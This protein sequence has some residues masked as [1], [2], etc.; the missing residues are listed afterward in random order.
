MQK[1]LLWSRRLAMPPPGKAIFT[2]P[3]V[4]RRKRNCRCCLS[5]RTT[6]TASVVPPAKSIP[7]P[8]MWF[9]RMIG[10]NSTAP[11]LG[12][13]MGQAPKAFAHIRAGEGP[14]FFWVMMERLSSHTSS[15]DQKLYRSAEELKRCEGCD[16]LRKW[17]EQLIAEGVMSE[18][19]YANL[20]N[21]IKERI[22][23]EFSDAEKEQDPSA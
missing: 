12:K 4:S 7:A 10:R 3:F 6:V 5:S 8:S 15:D 9:S 13:W 1:K 19:D 22:R 2:K 18:S 21:E 11:K 23:R 16:P 20:D 14:V 17:K